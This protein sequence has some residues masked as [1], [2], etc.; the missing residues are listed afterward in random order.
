MQADYIYKRNDGGTTYCYG[1]VQEG[2]NFSLV[3]D[4]E[5]MDGIAADVDTDE[6]NTWRK[7]C[8]YLENNYNSKIEQIEEC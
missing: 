4:D 1:T 5:Y 7:V 2:A 6:N 3:C 8:K